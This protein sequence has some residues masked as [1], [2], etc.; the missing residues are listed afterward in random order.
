MDKIHLRG[1]KFY[2][3]HGV[4]PE[5]QALGQRFSVDLAME[6]DLRAAGLSDNLE[7]TVSYSSVYKLVKEIMEGPSCKLLESLAETI[8]RRILERFDVESVHVCVDKPEVPMKGS[9]LENAGV[10]V[11]RQKNGVVG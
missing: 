11:Y 10:E 1:L 4:K 2:G 5:E 8:A 6:K 9:M 3:Y 7:D